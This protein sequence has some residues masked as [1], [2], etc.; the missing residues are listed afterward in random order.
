MFSIQGKEVNFY[1]KVANVVEEQALA[2]EVWASKKLHEHR[3]M[4]G[5]T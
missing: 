3:G 5:V 2:R 1:V 4:P